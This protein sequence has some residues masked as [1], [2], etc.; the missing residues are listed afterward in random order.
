MSRFVFW[1]VLACL[2]MFG[3][4]V[5][6][7]FTEKSSLFSSFLGSIGFLFSVG[8][9]LVLI[10]GIEKDYVQSG[11]VGLLFLLV[12]L[13]LFGFLLYLP[14]LFNFSNISLFKIIISLFFTTEM[15]YWLLGGDKKLRKG[16]VWFWFVLKKKGI[17]F[18]KALFTFLSC[19]VI[20][21]VVRVL[22]W[23]RVL[24]FVFKLVGFIG[25]GLLVLLSIAAIIVGY[26]WLNSWKYRRG[27]N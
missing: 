9:F 16:S 22:G 26:V 17:A 3:V 18:L 10:S 11:W 20:V 8:L 14:L 7:D 27:K 4:L 2:V 1:F 15:Y 13:S 19:N 12:I 21:N 5:S 25:V 23:K 6:V 24:I